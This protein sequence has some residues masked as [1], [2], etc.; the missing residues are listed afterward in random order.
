MSTPAHIRWLVLIISEQRIDQG[1]ANGQHPDGF[2]DETA[3]SLHQWTQKLLSANAPSPY[4]D[5]GPLAL[6]H[7]ALASGFIGIMKHL[8]T[9]HAESKQVQD[10]V[11]KVRRLW[12]WSGKWEDQA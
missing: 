8:K 6:S 12:T 1:L 3:K 5:A 7:A 2:D 4:G 10:A 9:H 11:R